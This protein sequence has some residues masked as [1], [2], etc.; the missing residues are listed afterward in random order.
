MKISK[1]KHGSE[2]SYTLGAT[3][4]IE[5]LKCKPQTVSEVFISS[6][7]AE[8]EI[9][10]ALCQKHNIPLTLNDKAFNILSP[11]GNCFVIGVFKK[12]N[13]YLE[14]GNHICLVNP[15]DSGNMGT[16]IRTAVGFG[17]KN[18][19]VISPAVDIFDPKTVRASMGAV[20]HVNYK[21]YDSFEQYAEEFKE[22]SK[23]A[24][25]LRRSKPLDKTVFNKPYSLIFGN[26]ATGLPDDFADFTNPVKIMHTDNIDSL[27]LPIAASIAMFAATKGEFE[28]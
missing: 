28:G 23:Y 4:T 21:Y 7:T 9:L 6:K 27:N 15:S 16:V 20:F 18:I 3:L 10:N 11:K 26:E 22:N 8:N 12:F 2:Y 14:K 5:L 13:D 1:Y 17:I 19:A 24:F 25:M